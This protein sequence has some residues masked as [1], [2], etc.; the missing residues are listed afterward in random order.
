MPPTS[1]SVPATITTNETFPATA[2]AARLDREV[3]LR[4]RAGAIRCTYRRQGGKWIMKT[5][6]NVIGGNG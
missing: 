3:D 5:E 4:L 2:T 6:W 1:A